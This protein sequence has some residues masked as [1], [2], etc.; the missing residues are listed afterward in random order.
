MPT[1]EKA[2]F[3][4]LASGAVKGIGMATARRMVEEFGRTP[5]RCWRTSRNG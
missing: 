4:Y 1:G 3:D 5:W 2:I